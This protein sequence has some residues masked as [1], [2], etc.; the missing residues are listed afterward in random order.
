ML[1]LA[2]GSDDFTW[3]YLVGTNLKSKP[4]YPNAA[5]AEWTYDAE[6]DL[7]AR[8]K[9]TKVVRDGNIRNGENN[10]KFTD[11]CFWNFGRWVCCEN[12]CRYQS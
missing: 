9:N 11:F 5:T 1:G 6:R 2:A 3:E 4:T 8:V 7:I 12:N 10:E